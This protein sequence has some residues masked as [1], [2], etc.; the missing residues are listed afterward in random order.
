MDTC[1]LISLL[2]PIS[3]KHSFPNWNGQ[4]SNKIMLFTF[5]SKHHLL[6]F[7][8][9]GE[10]DHDEEMD[11]RTTETTWAAKLKWFSIWRQHTFKNLYV[12]IKRYWINL[13]VNT[14][15]MFFKFLFNF[16]CIMSLKSGYWPYISC[17]GTWHQLQHDAQKHCFSRRLYDQED[18]LQL[19][20]H[21]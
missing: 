20:H 8:G 1:S 4:I 12:V 21:C 15:K 19:Q 13:A 11:D 10:S 17:P 16:F 9:G 6:K 2:S 14:I 18:H 7:E 5:S 3:R